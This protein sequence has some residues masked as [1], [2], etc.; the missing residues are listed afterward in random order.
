MSLLHTIGILTHPD[1]EWESIRADHETTSRLYLGHVLLLALIPA[2][3]A[4]YGTTQVGWTV[5]GSEPVKLTESSAAPVLAVLCCDAVRGVFNWPLYRLFF[6][7]LRCRR[8][9]T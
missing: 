1:K 2:G 3:A 9:R 5:A 8:K 7:D 6:N 4:F